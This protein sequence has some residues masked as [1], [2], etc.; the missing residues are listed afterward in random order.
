MATKSWNKLSTVLSEVLSETLDKASVQ[1]VMDSWNTK[2]TEVSKLMD[3]STG[4]K[5]KK[6]KDPNAPKRPSSSYILFCG[7]KRD[8]VKKANPKMSAT[9]ITS[10]LGE[11]WKSV[12]EKERKR[13][14]EA[15]AKDKVR[16]EKEMENYTPPAD[17]ESSGDEKPKR[18]RAKKE[19]EGPKR[20][21]TAYMYF[22]KENRDAVKADHP[23]MNGTAVTSE[24]GARWNA[25]SD[26]AKAPYEAKQAADKSR[27]EAEKAGGVE[28]PKKEKATKKEAPKET[29][30]D[31]P[32]ETKKESKKEAPKETPKETPKGKG[33]KE[34][35]K[36]EGKKT[37]ELKKTPGY[38]FFLSE[39]RDE[40]SSENPD[41]NSRKID[42]EVNKRWKELP[43][44]QREEY[45]L[46]AA[47][48]DENGSEVEL[49]D[50]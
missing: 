35:S 6:K 34:E 24:L 1:S 29:K 10:R 32:K 18:G 33:K 48:N 21:L 23:D 25:L 16:Y 27:Y 39:Q 7:E 26:S 17:S 41:W 12:S 36:K 19:R 3:T 43:D 4:G 20:P 30:K 15:S 45:E 37:S 42:T 9:E 47:A 8:D 22:C 28:A 14:E 40:I 11:M 2:K 5:S 31:T 46:E 49:E 13:F 38:E 44:E 50:E